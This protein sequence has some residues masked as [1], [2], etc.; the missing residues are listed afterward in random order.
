MVSSFSFSL[1]GTAAQRRSHVCWE[2]SPSLNLGQLASEPS[3]RCYTAFTNCTEKSECE[4]GVPYACPLQVRALL[5][6]KTLRLWHATAFCF[7][8]SV[9]HGSASC[10]CLWYPS[11]HSTSVAFIK[12]VTALPELKCIS[13]VLGNYHHQALISLFEGSLKYYC[14]TCRLE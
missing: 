1:E 5:T 13:P 12:T 7:S 11:Q 14:W 3:P 6:T 4:L 10:S 2:R 9:P 8:T